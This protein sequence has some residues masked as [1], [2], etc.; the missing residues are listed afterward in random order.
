M[1]IHLSTLFRTYSRQVFSN[2]RNVTYFFKDI[3]HIINYYHIIT[4]LFMMTQESSYKG[5]VIR[6]KILNMKRVDHIIRFH[7]NITKYI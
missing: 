2:L 1:V 7:F 4:D 3:S 6:S 5:N